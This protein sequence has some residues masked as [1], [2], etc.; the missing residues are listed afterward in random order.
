MLQEL[1]DDYDVMISRL[2]LTHLLDRIQIKNNLLF[3]TV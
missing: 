1:L 2:H 3:N